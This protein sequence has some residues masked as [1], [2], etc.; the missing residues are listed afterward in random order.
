MSEFFVEPNPISLTDTDLE[1]PFEKMMM[2]ENEENPKK[3][4]E[5]ELVILH[6]KMMNSHQDYMT[7]AMNY[8]LLLCTKIMEEDLQIKFSDNY[9]YIKEFYQLECK[10]LLYNEEMIEDYL[11]IRLEVIYENKENVLILTYYY[12]KDTGDKS[13]EVLL[14]DISIENRI[15]FENVMTRILDSALLKIFV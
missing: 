13:H 2:I 10:H 5:N 9:V 7:H 12:V 8:N 11:T 4:E 15:Q 1:I 6:Q 3:E 14:N